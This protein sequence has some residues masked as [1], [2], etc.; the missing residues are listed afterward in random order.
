M[1][2]KQYDERK[3]MDIKEFRAKGYLQEA[4][5]LF[6][7]PL[8]LAL[9]IMLEADGSEHLSGIWDYREDPEGIIYDLKNSDSDRLK[10]FQARADNIEKEMDKFSFQRTKNLGFAI[11]PIIIPKE[12]ENED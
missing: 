10:M 9:E 2:E 3:Y 12:E 7:H 8:G 6:F 1:K 5:R 4:N 11:E